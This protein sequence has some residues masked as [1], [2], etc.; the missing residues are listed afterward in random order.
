M[1]MMVVTVKVAVEPL[2]VAV[3]TVKIAHMIGHLMDPSAVIQLGMNMVLIALH[4]KAAITGIVLD[5]IAQ[6]IRQV[7]VVTAPVMLMKTVRPVKLIA[8]YVVSVVMV[9]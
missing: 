3:Q 5:V 2:V 6:V 1:I 9:K 7:N 4:W 8:A